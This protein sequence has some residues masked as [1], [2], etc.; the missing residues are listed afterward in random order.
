M[1]FVGAMYG[2]VVRQVAPRQPFEQHTMTEPSSPS[3][4]PESHSDSRRGRGKR[5]KNGGRLVGL[6]SAVVSCGRII[7][8]RTLSS[9]AVWWFRIGGQRRRQL[10]ALN[11]TTQT[12][13]R[14]LRV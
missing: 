7:E 12:Q 9:G 8:R 2:Q 1:G 4:R 14:A 5:M 13:G 6:G 11:T 3:G 10:H